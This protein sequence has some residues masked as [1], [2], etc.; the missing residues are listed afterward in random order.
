M[1]EY[2][3]LEE[4]KT[5]INQEEIDDDIL[6]ASNTKRG[7]VFV[8]NLPFTITEEKLKKEFEKFGEITEVNFLIKKDKLTKKRRK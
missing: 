8:R 4:N 1:E 5:T 3:N 7:R 6:E 2:K